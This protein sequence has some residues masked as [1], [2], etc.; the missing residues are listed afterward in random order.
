MG[1]HAPGP[2]P[3]RSAQTLSGRVV[4]AG[5]ASR[6]A[7][8][9]LLGIHVDPLPFR[10]TAAAWVDHAVELTVE[11]GPDP[12]VCRIERRTPE[13]R[14]LVLTDHLNVYFRGRSLPTA[15]TQSVLDRA[16][17]SLCD[18]TLEDLGAILR[19]DPELGRP[20]LPV[21]PSADEG[22]RPRSLLDTWGG[23]DS[24]ADFFAGGEIARSQLDSID[25]SRLFHFVQHCD[26]ECL[27]VNPHTVGTI[28]TLANY[29]WDERVRSPGIPTAQGMGNV[30]DVQ[31]VEEGMITTD[32][33]ENDVILG[34]PK[35]LANLVEY[36]ASRP[37]PE[38]K[39]VFVSNTCVP[40]VIGEDVESV[41]KRVRKRTGLPLLYLTVTP[42]SMNNVFEGL[43]VERRLAAEQT[44]P[45]P[46]PGTV[47][48]IGFPATRAVAELESL[49][50]DAGVR[51]NTR[52][53][54]ELDTD[55]IDALP[56]AA[57]NVVLPNRTWQNLYD[58]VLD[59][60]RLLSVFPEAPYGWDASR[61]WLVSIGA[62]L[63]V[64]LDVDGA[65]ERASS[66]SQRDWARLREEAARFRLGVVVRDRE[67]FF[68][69]TPAS[70]WGVPLLSCLEEMG[71]GIDVLV[72][73]SAPA[74]ARE[75]ALAIRKMLR[76]GSRHSVRAFDSF[77]FLRRRLQESPAQAFL[78]YHFFDWR[79]T[80]AGKG[81]FSI[82]HFEMGPAGAVRTLERL[83]AVCRT[84]FHRRYSRYLARTDEG[85]V[86]VPQRGG[87]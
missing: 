50:S 86:A 56:K 15:L 42:R 21:P 63:G 64:P 1:L 51:V 87:A 31:T 32:I 71:F 59:R 76:D 67:A 75:S 8:G 73:V 79:L 11:G 44:A 23:Q 61:R 26:N 69:T 4:A 35:K 53:L 65:W 66:S 29:P 52:L 20:G 33:D 24:W 84:P 54:P 37:N 6:H 36:A 41:V 5:A 70:T 49:L 13:S 83:L 48:L 77:A 46:D 62:G 12:V 2:K 10:V 85:L 47:N 38:R 45:A 81:S 58:Q 80:E 60:S 28:V 30:S 22:D 74:T 34:N 55:R 3:Q 27:F 57:M 82:Q 17:A 78:S 9:A 43:L 16:A 68:L 14:G 72:G 19:R 39:L 18:T 25:P 7:L 40:T